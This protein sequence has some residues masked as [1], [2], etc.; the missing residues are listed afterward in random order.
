MEY[1]D[2]KKLN[3][4]LET[5]S[6]T[7]NLI[8]VW[9]QGLSSV[10]QT[11]SGPTLSLG[12]TATTSASGFTFGGSTAP[13]LNLT[14][15]IKP[16]TTTAATGMYLGQLLLLFFVLNH[17]SLWFFNKILIIFFKLEVQ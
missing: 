9:F 14:T 2:F 17:Y 3:S 12:A 1:E 8:L 6:I 16:V 13:S 10:P 15:P 5:K 4:C 11:T 7:I